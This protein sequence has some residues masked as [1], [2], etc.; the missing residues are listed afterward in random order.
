MFEGIK[1][2][3]RSLFQRPDPAAHMFDHLAPR[4]LGEKIVK[5]GDPNH[6]HA[7][8]EM[9]WDPKYGK[10][11]DNFSSDNWWADYHYLFGCSCGA[12]MK[13]TLRALV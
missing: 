7:W 3:F 6:D 4:D 8:Y 1:K 10:S 5:P 13:K 11:V 12:R 9:D 2:L